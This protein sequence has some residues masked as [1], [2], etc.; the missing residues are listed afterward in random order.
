M[1]KMLQRL[2]LFVADVLGSNHTGYPVL[3]FRLEDDV[4]IV[5]HTILQRYDDE[6]KI[7]EHSLNSP[8]RT[9]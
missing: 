1:C 3:E 4:G 2:K 7:G 8:N 9:E 5:E 6:L